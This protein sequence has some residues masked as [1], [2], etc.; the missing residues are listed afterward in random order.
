MKLSMDAAEA[1]ALALHAQGFGGAPAGRDPSEVLSRISAVQLDT[2]AVL[3]RSHELV[4]YARIGPASRPAIERAYWGARPATAFEYPAHGVCL[5][6]AALWP[7][8]AFRR[9]EKLARMTAAG[10]PGR[11]LAEVRARL[12]DGPVTVTDLGGASRSGGWSE[13]SEA[14][15][16]AEWLWATGAIACTD[17]RGWKRV[18]DLP[19]RVL[20]ADLLAADPS[21]DECHDT[22]VRAAVTALGVATRRDIADYFWLRL[23]AVDAAVRRSDLIA[24]QVEGWPE[25][26]YTLPGTLGAA[27]GPAGRPALL[28]PFDSLIW[29]R[30]RM[31]RLFGVVVLLEAYRPK[32][33]R[34]HGYFT[35]AVLA[36][37]RIAGRVDPA[38]DGSTLVV[39]HAC[40]EEP[41]AAADLV[42]A[43]RAAATWVACDDIVVEHTEPAG[44]ADRLRQLLRS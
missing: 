29:S 17:R 24:V 21:D 33:Q 34:L 11:A 8:F 9:R 4:Q 2:I 23:R 37:G 15:T 44:L 14:K 5:L 22:L 16:M 13:W 40:L 42:A 12:A 25:V 41:D 31:R 1:T 43:V 32:P 35:M 26:G 36:S 10:P 27:T 39:R 20:P 28:S 3:A 30:E 19:E 18:Y 38:R 7:S 6:P